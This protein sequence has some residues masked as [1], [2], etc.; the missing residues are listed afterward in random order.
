MSNFDNLDFHPIVNRLTEIISAKTQNKD[1][2]FFRVMTSYY[3]AKIASMMRVSIRSDIMD[4]PIPVNLYAINLSPS[5]SGKGR[6]M[7]IIEDQVINKFREHFMARTFPAIAE[8]TM[9]RH[10]VKRANKNASDPETEMEIIRGEFELAGSML[11]SFDSATT[12]AIKQMRHKLLLAGSGSMNMEIDE[13]GSNL[14]SNADVLNSFLELY[15]TGKIKQKLVKNTRDNQRTAEL[16]GSTPTNMLLFGTP[17]KLLDGA[18]T[19]EEF[20]SM[21]ETGFARRCFFGYSSNTYK[22]KKRSAEEIYEMLTDKSAENYLLNLSDNLGVLAEATNFNS[23][24]DIPQDVTLRLI[25]YQEYCKDRAESYTDYEE[26]R[27]SE[28]THRYFKVAKL[29]GVYAF[30]DQAMHV[31]ED[32]LNYAVAMAEHSGNAFERILKREKPYVKLASYICSIGRDVTHA[33]LTDELP[34]YKG[35]EAAR[36]DLLK[37]AIAHGYKNNQII[38]ID[39][40]DD[41]EILTGSSLPETDLSEI[42]LSY[43]AEYTKFYRNEVGKFT[44]L[45]KLCTSKGHHWCNHHL[46]E[47]AD[48]PNT[49]GYRD[50]N[51]AV[52]GFNI[53]VIDVDGGIDMNTVSMLLEDYTWFMH[54]TKSHTDKNHRFRLI[55]PIS[56]VLELNAKDYKEFMSNVFQWLP[57]ECDTQTN[58]RS[59]K[60]ETFPGDYKYNSGDLLDAFKFIPKTRKAEEQKR[61]MTQLSSLNNLERWFV[62]KGKEGNRNNMLLRYGYVLVDMGLDYNSIINNIHALNSRLDSPLS[63]DELLNTVMPSVSKKL[64]EKATVAN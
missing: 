57:F 40:I 9:A 55:M 2:M 46:A 62:A 31:T 3:L 7:N 43:S 33:D 48:Y 53:V 42:Q 50:E 41:V 47:H 28:M 49:G 36:K 27:K 64:H 5:G 13:I 51:H 58:Q 16:F 10:S 25:E 11:F 52:T 20:T 60:W 15:D 21:L 61:E 26:A 14:L 45:H 63:D 39:K 17:V 44:Q 18:K 8:T 34:F 6:S 59:R 19:E 22:P 54:T 12:A 56:H 1:L 4:T 23:V 35:S 38:K 32:H 24:I 30:I 37:L 29:A